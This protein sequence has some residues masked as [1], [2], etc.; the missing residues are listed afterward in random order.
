MRSP[1]VQQNETMM[2]I[3]VT[4]IIDV[5]LVLVIILLITAPMITAPSLEVDLPGAQTRAEDETNRLNITLSSSGEIAIDEDSIDSTAL[6]P[7]LK[8]RLSASDKDLLVVVRADQATPYP[9]VETVLKQ[10][11]EAGAKRIAIATRHRER[12]RAW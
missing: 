6:L 4:P 10:S 11:R 1:I 5:A 7:E 8:R 2:R 12:A 9:M 3:N